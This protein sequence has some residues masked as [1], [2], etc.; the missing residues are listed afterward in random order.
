MVVYWFTVYWAIRQHMRLLLCLVGSITRLTRRLTYPPDVTISYCERR[1]PPPLLPFLAVPKD[2][3]R[4]MIFLH[5]T[6]I[7]LYVHWTRPL[8]CQCVRCS[9][10]FFVAS[11]GAEQDRRAKQRS[12]PPSPQPQP[13]K[14]TMLWGYGVVRFPSCSCS[15]NMTLVI[16]RNFEHID[17]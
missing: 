15:C 12:N 2:W 6:L 4:Q 5:F 17:V 8:S 1:P 14:T 3:V 11:F 10:V 9:F 7:L 13:L 16:V